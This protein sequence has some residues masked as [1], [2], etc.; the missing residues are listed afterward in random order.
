MNMLASI[1]KIKNSL[2]YTLLLVVV[3]TS[4]CKKAAPTTYIYGV[5]G[6]GV[7]QDGVS[8]P[9]VKS[10][11][12]F[13]SI[14]YS[15]LFGNTINQATLTD[16]STAY[17]SFAD[18]KLIEDMIIRN[19]LNTPGIDIPTLTEMNASLPTFIINSYKKF[20]NREPNEF[21]LWQMQN[22]IESDSTITPELVYYA[23]MT[24]N[25]YRYY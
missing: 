11:V 6:V 12:E 14:A 18:K 15:D 3:F 7:T 13:I 24:S 23:F 2:F 8:K 19:F 16:L 10:T 9:N 21:E 20:Y 5:N 4:S 17:V 22:L 1:N 25:E